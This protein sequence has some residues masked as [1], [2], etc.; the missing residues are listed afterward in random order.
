MTLAEA[1]I[2]RL[3]VGLGISGQATARYCQRMGWSFDLCDSRTDC[4]A[5]SSLSTLF[6]AANLYL[7]ALDGQR[8][9]AYQ[10]IIVSPGVALSDPALQQALAAGV[11][12]IGDVELFARQ[13]RVPVIAITGS[14]GKSTVTTLVRDILRDAG[15]AAEM[16]GNIGVPVL[17]LL[18]GPQPDVY[19][20]E[21][22]S[23]QL[24]TT[25]SLKARVATI[26]N[27]SEDHMD[28]YQGMAAYQLAKQRIFTGCELAVVNRDDAAS[29]PCGEIIEA[30]GF[31]IKA[32]TEDDFGLQAGDCDG[33][34]GDWIVRAGMQLVH[35]SELKIHGRHNLANVM[36]ALALV[37]TVG[38]SPAQARMTLSRFTG[39][40]HRCEW[41][42]E[43]NGVV[44]INDS[45]GTNVGSTL[46]AIQGLTGQ[47]GA[48]WLLAGGD[49][50]QQ[51]F[52]PL[53]PACA[54]GVAGVCCFGQDGEAL[55]AT[56]SDSCPTYSC[57]Y[58][59]EAFALAVAKAQPG[60]RVLLSPACAS[61]DQFANYVERGRHF[62]ALVGSLM[63]D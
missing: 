23:F 62:G 22:S 7:G 33:V 47:S 60:D 46:A 36:A 30:A 18:A 63:D 38:V 52:Q 14:N 48:L 34:A 61:L 44:F 19:V 49:G 20:L 45:K 56:L 39:L 40:A 41:V 25:A 35:S 57:Q 9:S 27:L 6:P 13:N 29:N 55:A 31:T 54:T 4:P 3:I 32:P 5:A 28:R 21:L 42:G 15:V 2:K 11:D 58:L 12:V 50:K 1:D 51:D 43:H 16:G 24:E 59:A 8:L 53:A 10:Q 37:E 26:L 17:D